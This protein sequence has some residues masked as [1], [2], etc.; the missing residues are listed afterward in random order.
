MEQNKMETIEQ[1][2]KSERKQTRMQ[3]LKKPIREFMQKHYT[4]ERLAQLLAHAQDGKLSYWSCCCFIGVATA[5]H[6]LMDG[7]VH[8]WDQSHYSVATELSGARKAELNYC[9]I[10]SHLI[11]PMVT[12]ARDAYRIKILIPMIRAEMKRRDALASKPIATE[13][14]LAEVQR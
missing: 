10:G 12:G 8:H 5:D 3:E 6:A 1:A 4:D 9:L 7:D 2:T 14:A 11:G 13:E